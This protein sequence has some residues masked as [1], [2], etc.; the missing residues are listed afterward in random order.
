M[1]VVSVAVVLAGTAGTSLSLG[2]PLLEERYSFF[3]GSDLELFEG[4]HPLLLVFWSTASYVVVFG[5]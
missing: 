2:D 5:D 1:S 4:I 3:E